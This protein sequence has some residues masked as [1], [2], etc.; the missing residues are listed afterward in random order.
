[1]EALR[2]QKSRNPLYTDLIASNVEMGDAAF[3]SVLDRETTN[4]SSSES[5]AKE[6]LEVL[7]L[8]DP[9]HLSAHVGQESWR[10]LTGL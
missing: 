8:I 7:A 9:K 5:I 1:M 2:P 3:R 6:A 4:E 10:P